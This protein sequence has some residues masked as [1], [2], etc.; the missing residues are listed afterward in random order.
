ME[1][2]TLS[3]S[4][5]GTYENSQNQTLESC[6]WL[7]QEVVRG[8]RKQAC[9]PGVGELVTPLRPLC[10]RPSSAHSCSVHFYAMLR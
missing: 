8:R 7:S 9:P 10:A 5:C 2:S 6:P 1:A 3:G 4:I